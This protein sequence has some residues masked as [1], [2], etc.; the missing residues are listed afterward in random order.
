M[1]FDALAPVYR[2]MERALA[3]GRLQRCR[4]VLLPRLGGAREVLV[5][6]EGPGRWI[7]AAGRAL[8]A[9]RFTVVDASAGMLV[10]AER[11]WFQAGGEPGRIRFVQARLPAP[12]PGGDGC[13]DLIVTPFFL[14]CFAPGPLADV[15]CGLS[16]AATADARWLVCDFRVPARGPAR[17][18]A[19]GV[20]ALAH[21]FFRRVTDMSARRLTD[22]APWLGAQ[23]F[24]LESEAVSEWGLL[25]A[26]LWRRGGVAKPADL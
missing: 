2:T 25:G 12:L 16:A 5:A 17:W 10:R 24:H 8:P 14:D 23:G 9:A 7:E 11:A 18:R 1:S 3:G 13:Y 4:T 6:G 19:Q 21:W 26:A 20:L 22:P 15:I